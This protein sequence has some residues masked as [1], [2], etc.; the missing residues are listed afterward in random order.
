MKIKN[1]G[2]AL[3]A[4]GEEIRDHDL[5]LTLINNVG[6]DFDT[7]VAVISTQQRFI[8]LEDAHFLLMMHE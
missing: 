3:M 7:I 4:A 1:I 8:S 6:H 2:D 5:V